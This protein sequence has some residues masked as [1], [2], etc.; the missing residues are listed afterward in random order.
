M[1][2]SNII[3]IVHNIHSENKTCQL[4]LVTYIF[5]KKRDCFRTL[6]VIWIDR[7]SLNM[8]NISHFK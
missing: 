1:I 7:K 5:A 6:L 3:D 4:K 8:P 2:H